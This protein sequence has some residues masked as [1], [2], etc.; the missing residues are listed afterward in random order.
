MNRFAE[1]TF[2]ERGESLTWSGTELAV[3]VAPATRIGRALSDR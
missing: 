3:P 2:L 1:K